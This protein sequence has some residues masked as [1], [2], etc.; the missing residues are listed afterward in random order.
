MNKE[1]GSSLQKKSQSFREIMQTENRRGLVVK[2]TAITKSPFDVPGVDLGISTQEIVQFVRENRR[3][4]D[5]KKL[6][7]G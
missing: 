4:Y 3:P 7:F 5:E 6:G 1:M 2:S